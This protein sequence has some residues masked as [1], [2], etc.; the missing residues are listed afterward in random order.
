MSAWAAAVPDGYRRLSGSER[1]LGLHSTRLGPGDVE[2]E[3]GDFEGW[4]RLRLSMQRHQQ[5]Q[6]KQETDHYMV[7]LL[8]C[9]EP[10]NG[11]GVKPTTCYFEPLELA[12]PPFGVMPSDQPNSTPSDIR[13]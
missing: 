1:L 12:Y 4:V 6:D 9:D 13:C 10:M 2:L 8:Q 5:N 11:F 3:I 7:R